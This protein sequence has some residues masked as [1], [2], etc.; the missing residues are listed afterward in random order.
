MQRTDHRLG[1]AAVHPTRREMLRFLPLGLRTRAGC[2]R[3]TRQPV[4][5][6]TACHREQPRGR[7]YSS[8]NLGWRIR[9]EIPRVFSAATLS[10]RTQRA[11]SGG[12]R[13][14]RCAVNSRAASLRNGTRAGAAATNANQ[15]HANVLVPWVP[16]YESIGVGMGA[17]GTKL[18]GAEA[19]ARAQSNEQN[20]RMAPP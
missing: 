17:S 1:V 18:S 13:S 9:T 4:A 3:Q 2:P 19:K 5:S 20:R 15:P 16:E 8:L 6:A 14:L 11:P 7:R 10:P 12:S